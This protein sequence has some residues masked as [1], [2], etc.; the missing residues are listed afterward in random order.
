MLHRR[1]LD[2]RTGELESA[3]SEIREELP[4]R[5]FFSISLTLCGL[6]PLE[7]RARW[8]LSKHV[9]SCRNGLL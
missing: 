6:P 2:D 8:E 1:K 3:L 5:E 9:F 7:R 4:Q